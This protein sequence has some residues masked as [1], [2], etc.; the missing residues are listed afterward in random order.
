MQKGGKLESVVI[1][2]IFGFLLAFLNSSID[3]MK[4]QYSEKEL[5][6]SFSEDTIEDLCRKRPYFWQVVE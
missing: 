2:I 1:Q 4:S 5:G 3:N 6:L